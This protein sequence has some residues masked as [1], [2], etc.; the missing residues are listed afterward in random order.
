MNKKIA[1][2]KEVEKGIYLNLKVSA[3]QK[4]TRI[5]GID[6]WRNAL[7]VS[8]GAAPVSGKANMELLKLLE[9]IF[10]EAKGGIIIVKGQK[11][12]MKKIFIPI[13]S[14]LAIE[15]LGLDR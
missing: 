6:I 7:E 9:G 10:P 2:I 3:N 4:E 13:S 11:S 5:G 14:T 8:I 1:A 12:S 15:R